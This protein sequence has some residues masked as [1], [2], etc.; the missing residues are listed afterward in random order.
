[1]QTLTLLSYDVR[2]L[3][4]LWNEA[5]GDRYPMREALLGR[6]LW[7]DLNFLPEASFAAVVD[8]QLAGMVAAKINREFTGAPVTRA[9]YINS[10]IVHPR[11]QRRGIGTGLLRTATR[12]LRAYKP[13][14]I[15]LGRDT[16]H[17][18]PAVPQDCPDALA[19]FTKM[20]AHF[21]GKVETDLMRELHDFT[22]PSDV[23]GTL[24]R[25]PVEIR[26]CKTDEVS[27]LADHL[28]RTFPGRWQYEFSKFLYDGGDP[29]DYMIVREQ[30]R[31]I[32]FCHMYTPESVWIGPSTY[33]APL[34]PQ[35]RF[36]GYGPLGVDQETRGRG[37][38]LAV[39]ACAIAE[40][41][42]RGVTRCGVDWTGLVDFY[43]R[44]GF[45]PWKRYNTAEL[46][47]TE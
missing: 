20:G 33:W 14:R 12:A 6:H 27:L 42:R 43:G 41:K 16:F 3:T 9:G 11:Y 31:V 39:V 15:H 5:L 46:N 34:Y 47:L 1:M 24:E 2:D 18:F 10:L 25:E 17:L 38:G 26:P 37:L 45:V 8:G 22:L 32:G 4:T 13:E 30:D 7:G 21:S 36:G 29:A 19:F 23:V 44:L 35:D 28:R 40:L